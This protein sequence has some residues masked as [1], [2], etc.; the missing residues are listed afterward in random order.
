MGRARGIGR[1]R[2]YLGEY[3]SIPLSIAEKELLKINIE[4]HIYRAYSR[5]YGQVIKIPNMYNQKAL[6]IANTMNFKELS[7][8]TFDEKYPAASIQYTANIIFKTIV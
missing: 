7:K 4:S 2:E 5:S 8:F 6:D 3:K 1:V